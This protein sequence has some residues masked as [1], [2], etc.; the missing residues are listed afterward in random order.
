M[1]D[2]AATF[3]MSAKLAPAADT[4]AQ[5]IHCHGLA[6]QEQYAKEPEQA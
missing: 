3:G 1:L 4:P 2:A 6:T 5:T